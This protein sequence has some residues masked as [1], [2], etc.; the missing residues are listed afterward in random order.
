MS[1]YTPI[2]PPFA[3]E[4]ANAHALMYMEPPEGGHMGGGLFYYYIVGGGGLYAWSPR[5][6]KEVYVG[7]AD[8]RVFVEHK[9]VQ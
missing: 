2:P 3:P 1:V 6:R 8:E 7:V 5:C 9:I 4:H